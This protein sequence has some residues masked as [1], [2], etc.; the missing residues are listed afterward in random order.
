MITPVKKS[1]TVVLVGVITRLQ[2]EEQ[3]TEYL[4]ELEFLAL[5]AGATTLKRF[6]Q[7]VDLPNSATFIGQGKMYEIKDYILEHKVDTVIF[8]DELTPSQLR[9]SGKKHLKLKFSTGLTSF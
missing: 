1:E 8:D 3:V 7:K 2:P 9:E 5:T 6:V 4:D